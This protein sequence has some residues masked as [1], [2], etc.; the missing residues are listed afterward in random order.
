MEKINQVIEAALE[1]SKIPY[2]A[3]A[4]TNSKETLLSGSVGFSDPERTSTVK[5]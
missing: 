1:E 4:V 5:L 3:Y 2:A